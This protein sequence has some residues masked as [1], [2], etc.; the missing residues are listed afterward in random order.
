MALCEVVCDVYGLIDGR[1]IAVAWSRR[2]L[3][4][5]AAGVPRFGMFD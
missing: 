5:V 1:V 2:C 3:Q 4:L